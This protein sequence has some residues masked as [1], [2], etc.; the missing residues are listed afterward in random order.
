MFK[1]KIALVTGSGRGIGASIAKH[2]AS[3]GSD[4]VV[5]YFRNPQSA[6]ETA[7]GIRQLG[8]KALLVKANMGDPDDIERL[9]AAI[10]QEFGGLDYYIHNAASGYNRPVMQQKVKGW[11]WTM[12]INAAVALI[13]SPEGC[14]LNGETWWRGDRRHLQPGCWAGS[15]RLCGGGSQQS[16]PG[17]HHSLPGSGAFSQ[18]YRGQRHFTRHDP[19]G[20]PSALRDGALGYSPGGKGGEYHPGWQA[21]QPTGCGWTGCLPVLT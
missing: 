19:D 16:R 11:N 17:I 18:E 7:E 9:F 12:N 14:A 4:V 15:A 10:E 13:C 2:F 6:K 3:L 8:R 5:N 21:G 1:N 20:R